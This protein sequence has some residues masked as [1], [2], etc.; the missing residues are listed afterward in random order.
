M[1]TTQ[2]ATPFRVFGR[3]RPSP[4]ARRFGYGVA[5][6]V[7]AGLLYVVNNLV[8]WGWPAFLTEEFD[9]VLPLLNVS[10]I[11]G[12]VVNAVYIAFDEPWFKTAGD[13][14][15]S[16][17]SL[18]VVAR[19]LAVFPFDFSVYDFD[20]ET[21]TRV[22]LVLMIVALG[23]AILAGTVQLVVDAARGQAASPEGGSPG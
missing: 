6:A 22:C 4:A 5:I 19:M 8:A 3:K 18:A 15:T 7:N 14:V 12:M 16:A 17:L 11:A 13:V 2:Q 1:T 20:W 21:L 9:G 10:I 23:I